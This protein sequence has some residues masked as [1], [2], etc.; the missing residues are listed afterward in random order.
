MST[1]RFL[2]VGIIGLSFFIT[3]LITVLLVNDMRNLAGKMH[4][5]LDDI[6]SVVAETKQQSDDAKS[7]TLGDRVAQITMESGQNQVETVANDL[8]GKI[9]G[10]M[11]IPFSSARTVASTVLAYLDYCEKNEIEPDRVFVRALLKDLLSRDEQLQAI[12]V[13]FEPNEF[14]GNDE[15]FVGK[16]VRDDPVVVPNPDFVSRGQ[17]IPWFYREDE[18]ILEN[19]LDDMYNEDQDYYTGALQSGEEYITSP[20]FDET[21]LISTIAI[22]LKRQGKTIGVLGVDVSVSDLQNII[23][24]SKPLETGVGILVSPDG[25]FVVHPNKDRQDWNEEIEEDGKKK[26]ERKEIARIPG[27]EETAKFLEAGESVAYTNK[28]I[29]GDSSKDEMQVIHLPVYPGNT[30]A[31]WTVIVAVPLEQV[32]KSRN[33]AEAAISDVVKDMQKSSE[34]SEQLAMKSIWRAVYVGTGVLVLSLILG[35]LLANFVNKKVDEKDHWYRQVLDTVH[36]P[37]S[38]VDMGKCITFVNKVAV[39]LLGK[40]ETDYTKLPHT[41]VWGPDMDK[42][43]ALLESRQEKMTT[44]EL[45]ER[46]W[47]VYTDFL[48][49][50]NGQTNGMIEFFKDVTDRETVLKIAQEIENAVSQAV[51]HTEQITS[52]SAQLSAG[53]EEQAASLNEI[54]SNMTTMSERTKRNA[55]NANTANRLT[56]ESVQ[57]AK[58]G[59]TRMQQMIEQ[60]SQISANASNMRKVIKTIDDIAFQTNLLALNAAVEAA[61]AG[62]HGKGFAVVAEEVRNL[63]ARSAKAAKETEDL[64]L[65]S[66]TQIDNGVETANQTAEALNA[67]AEQVA[68]ATELVSSIASSSQ[69]QAEEVLKINA[70]LAQVGGVTQQNSQTANQTASVAHDLNEEIHELS[71]MMEKFR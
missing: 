55:D 42:P 41:T 10:A 38:V 46:S 58:T 67:I 68:K 29:L 21:A 24:E 32:M 12:F 50:S 27:L 33:E 11:D 4:E 17:F 34:E 54:T 35:V 66:N 1:G 3:A 39:E 71:A 60:M 47:E 59:Q 15:A 61:R 18:K 70:T 20:Y 2:V 37:I 6:V 5:R 44:C 53:S 65:K 23:D 8:A 43:L 7:P 52:D 57:A 62:T 13:G 16:D 40:K 30:A 64:I 22:P 31:P 25:K 9:K 19:I 69:E 36:A 45:A 51:N 49:E 14:D 26:I 63:A 28:T 48:R 56:N